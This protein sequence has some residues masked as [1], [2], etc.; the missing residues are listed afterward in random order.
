M[1]GKR[2]IATLLCL[3]LVLL[4]L[5]AAGFAEAEEK[6]I[7]FSDLTELQGLCL[8]AGGETEEL[9]ICEAE[10]PFL[11]SEN[12]VIPSGITVRFRQFTVEEGTVLTLDENARILTIGFRVEG[13][14]V[15]AGTV[16]QR[17]SSDDEA[18]EIEVSAWVPGKV[19]NRGTMELTNVYGVRNIHNY[20]G[21]LT[22]ERTEQPEP[23]ESPEPGPDEKTP[24]ETEPPLPTM[25][26][27]PAP[28]LRKLLPEG[29]TEFLEDD[30]LPGVMVFVFLLVLGLIRK[31]AAGKAKR[32]APGAGGTKTLPKQRRDPRM[33]TFTEPEPYC[34]VCESSGEDHFQR[35]KRNRI[36]QLDEWLKN[37][38]ID[39]K[40]YLELKRRYEQD[41]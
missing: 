2:I 15:N 8:A 18:G 24:G 22:M 35:D 33:K 25:S 41:L 23:D 5:P 7:Y 12:L 16:I 6:G 19:I 36:A 26:P 21:S 1:N 31:K 29:L 39:R 27:D 17:A 38:L 4:M 32:R 11:I 28:G 14:F 30:L 13:E 20:R 9:L 3:V 37:G 10:G 34:V 40:E